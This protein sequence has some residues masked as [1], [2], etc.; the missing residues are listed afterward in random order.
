MYAVYRTLHQIC[1]PHLDTGVRLWR[2][3]P[4]HCPLQCIHAVLCS[5]PGFA[6]RLS[7]GWGGGK[8]YFKR[9]IINNK[10]E[11]GYGNVRERGPHEQT[12]KQEE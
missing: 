8:G 12:G 4:A 5:P 11:I 10:G 9:L 7:L 1:S 6:L 3:N 2:T